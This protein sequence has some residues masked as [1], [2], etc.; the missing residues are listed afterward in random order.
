MLFDTDIVPSKNERFE[1][2]DGYT[3][4]EKVQALTSAFFFGTHGRE[5][6]SMAKQWRVAELAPANFS[7]SMDVDSPIVKQL[8]WNRGLRDAETIEAFLHPTWEK[9][10]HD[11]QQFRHLKAATDVLFG[12]LERGERITVHGDYDADGVTGSTVMITTLREIEKQIRRTETPPSLPLSGEE[13][14]HPTDKG[15]GGGS[16]HGSLVDFYIPHRD[17]EGYGLNKETVLKLK[18]RETKVIVTVD[19]GIACVEEI[20]LAKEQGMVTIV[21]D[22]HTFGDELPD[23]HLIHPGIPEETYP[24]KSLAAVGV[25]FKFAGALLDEARSR[26]L[27]IPVGWEKWLLDLVAIATVTDMVPLIGENRV[28]ET[29]GL[30][31][32]NKTRRPG[33]RALIETSRLSYG[34]ID[35]ESVGFA[36]GPR[37]NAAGRMEHAELALHLL[38]SE[39]DEEAMGHALAL[40]RCNKS[41]QE[42]TKKMMAEAE[43][44]MPEQVPLALAFWDGGWSPSLVGLVAGRFADRFARPSIAIGRHGET[45]IG[46]GRSVP[47]F[48]ITQAMR[49]A[50]EGILT[51]IGGHPQACGFALKDESLL[52]ELADRLRTHAESLLTE[53]D[54]V[55]ALAIDAEMP[56]EF[57]GWPL[58]NA[59]SAME[60]FGEGNRQP[61]FLSRRCLVASSQ[62]VGTTGNVLRMA[63]LTKDARKI[64]AVGFKLGSRAAEFTPGR[65][66]DIVYTVG[67]NEWNGRRD[68]ECRLVDLQ[69]ST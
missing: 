12:A 51:R 2:L 67:I 33:L 3:E 48:D 18:A 14:R 15:N 10:L 28:L 39:T 24:F 57:I 32:L 22:H 53:S 56:L 52:P 4:S 49:K 31:V 44:K 23:G 63:L 61:V 29:Y 17:K 64:M 37:L 8:L 43:L 1:P 54:L 21:V 27:D 38:L 41:R 62:A 55:P 25:A 34:S 59:V 65:L 6:S 42:A 9:H 68:L 60:P 5:W 19:C 50:G 13:F 35:S 11:A 45:W 16:F 36:I 26:G 47:G 66:V 40:E 69:P 46:S 7:P 30:Q 20:R 58:V